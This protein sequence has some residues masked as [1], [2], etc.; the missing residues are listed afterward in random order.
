M[1]KLIL[2]LVAM[3]VAAPLMAAQGNPDSINLLITPATEISVNID[4]A[5]YTFKDADDANLALGTT[6]TTT[7][8]I[9]ITNDGNIRTKWQA[10]VGNDDWTAENSGTGALTQNEFRLGVIVQ[11]S[12]PADT[13]FD[14]HSSGCRVQSDASNDITGATQK[15][16]S[17]AENMWLRLELPME[18]DAAGSAAQ[19]LVLSITAV[20]D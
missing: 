18:V 11:A 9:L 13:D 8:A 16:P 12:A 20:A 5:S 6:C 7:S 4:L 19:T 14:T 3:L 15:N 2:V 17:D 10:Q 1:R